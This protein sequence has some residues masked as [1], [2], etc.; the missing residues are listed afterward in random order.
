MNLENNGSYSQ[1]IKESPGN[2]IDEQSMA[3]QSF[4]YAEIIA[5]DA[6]LGDIPFE[7]IIERIEK[8][9]D[10]YINMEDDTDYVDIFYMQLHA[11]YTAID[12]DDEEEHPMEIREALDKFRQTFTDFLTVQFRERL[13]ITFSAIE[14]EDIDQ[15]ELESCFWEAYKYFILNAR[16]NFTEVISRDVIKRLKVEHLDEDAYFKRCGELMILYSPLIS[17]LTPSEFLEYTEG[18][19]GHEISEMYEDGEIVGNFLRKYSPKL[20]QNEELQVEIINQVM[21]NYQYWEEYL[22]GGNK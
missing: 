5:H 13:T 2:G 20:Y 11:S 3:D 1:E 15:D 12:N 10:D 21:I 4:D 9:F 8:Q 17:G 16:R 19:G 6:F 18:Q 7:V 22:N 14:A